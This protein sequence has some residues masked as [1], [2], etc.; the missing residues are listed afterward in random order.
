ML[1]YT[2]LLFLATTASAC[3]WHSGAAV[4]QKWE[5]REVF[6]LVTGQ[7]PEH[8]ELMYEL[9]EIRRL[10]ALRWDV[11][12]REA[13]VDLAYSRLGLGRPEEALRVL[14]WVR[15]FS[16]GRFETLTLQSACH[17]RLGDFERAEA[18]LDEA[19]RLSPDACPGLGDY[20][21]RTLRWLWSHG[22]R[23]FLGVAYADWPRASVGADYARLCRLVARFPHFA[24]AL[25]VLGDELYRRG[26]D[27]LAVWAWVRAL[28]LGHP[29][30]NEIRRRLET[31]FVL[32][33]LGEGRSAGAVDE[34]IAAIEASQEK[35]QAWRN[36]YRKSEY[37]LDLA[38]RDVSFPAV[39]RELALRG[40][41]RMRGDTVTALPIHERDRAIAARGLMPASPTNE[42]RASTLS[43][44]SRA[45]AVFALA[46]A[47]A[48]V[49]LAGLTGFL[50][51]ALWS[52]RKRRGAGRFHAVCPRRLVGVF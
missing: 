26:A 28:H 37:L 12:D 27:T 30:R 6:D 18:E 42:T 9:L 2:S 21:L 14:S 23:N 51:R 44:K 17:E 43:G 1:R 19:L 10:A 34:A 47:F 22:A 32:S 13:R 3:P 31:T 33:R 15:Q 36:E 29:A 41:R 35:A 49:I 40:V 8:G 11:A 50:F 46:A 4:D 39:E 16:P 24:D 5:T 45:A 20:H 52:P 7:V 48:L 25:L 38:G